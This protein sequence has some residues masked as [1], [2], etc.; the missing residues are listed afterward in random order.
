MCA[1]LWQ[2]ENGPMILGAL[3]PLDAEL[4]EVIELLRENLQSS[5]APFFVKSACADYESK[6]VRQVPRRI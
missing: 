2:K 4:D 6:V 1:K 5:D 3:P